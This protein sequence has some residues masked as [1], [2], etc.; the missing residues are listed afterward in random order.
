MKHLDV[1]NFG[2]GWQ[3]TGI[4]VLIE[5]GKL[6][7]PDRI[8]IAD[9][10][11]EKQSTWDYLETT[12]RPRMAAIGLEIEIAPRSLAKVDIYSHQGTLLLPV[13][14]PTGKMSAFCSSEWKARVIDRYIRQTGGPIE[15]ERRH[16]IGFAYDERRRIKGDTSRYY[17]LVEAMLTRADVRALVRASDWPDPTSSACWMCPNMTNAQWR[18]IRD[19]RPDEF[20][21]ACVMD[22]ETREENLLSHGLP[23]WLHESRGPLREADLEAPD[24]DEVGRQCGLG[25]CMV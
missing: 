16:W 23:C 1:M 18:E 7:R 8:V 11:R 17:P 22:E 20:E 15:A 9:T 19:N 6:P 24:R 3:T 10:G 5:Q 4:L 21:R 2:G 25:L 12:A 13:Y 14:T